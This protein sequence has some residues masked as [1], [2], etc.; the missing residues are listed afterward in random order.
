MYEVKMKGGGNVKPVRQKRK[1]NWWKYLLTFIGGFS[2]CIFAFV[3]GVAFTGRSVRMK[4]V[5]SLAGGNPD[6]YIGPKYQNE[7][8]E[9]MI[10]ETN[11][12]AFPFASGI[13]K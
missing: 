3:I 12:N 6:D 13:N 8:I 10:K 11:F 7:T 9:G 5:V 4:D 2:F 1:S